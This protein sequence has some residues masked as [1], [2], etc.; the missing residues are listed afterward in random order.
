MPVTGISYQDAQA[1]AAWRAKQLRGA[2]LCS[3]AEW[4]RAARGADDRLYPHGDLLSADD[5][6]HDATYGRHPLGFGPDEVGQH[7]TT[8]S[9]FGVDDLA[10][11]VWE[12]VRGAA[13]GAVVLRGGAWY[14]EALVALST[15]RQFAEPTLRGILIGF[16]LCAD[17]P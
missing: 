11:N 6:N 5:A 3:E 14:Q 2:R 7:P 17:P 4:E 8:K 9:P 16:R 1:Y 15:N 10:G 13:P 12:L